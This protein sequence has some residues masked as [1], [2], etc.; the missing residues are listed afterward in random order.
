MNWEAIG[1]IGE[2]VGAIA[3]VTT[4]IV[5]LFQVRQ[6]TQSMIE[7]NRLQKAAAI[8]KHADSIGGWRNN[9]INDEKVASI[10][11]AM[12]EGEELSDLDTIRFD[13]LWVN[14]VNIQRSNYVRANVVGES[15][16]AQQAVMSVAVELA[17]SEKFETGWSVTRNWHQLASP[18]FVAAV[19]EEFGKVKISGTEH[20][21][22]GTYHKGVLEPQN[23]KD[24]ASI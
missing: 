24:Q 7:A 3:V 15:G 9:F 14:F 10:W 13:N 2:V 23:S 20:Q 21:T 8:D 12:R 6:N 17:N 1:A 18:D 5:L 22:P 16:L 4:L 11:I 19:E